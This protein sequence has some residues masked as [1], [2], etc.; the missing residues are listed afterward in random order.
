MTLAR[1]ADIEQAHQTARDAAA[2]LT[3]DLDA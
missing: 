3:I 1:G 2:A